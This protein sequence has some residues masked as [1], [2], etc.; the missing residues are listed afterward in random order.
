MLTSIIS[1]NLRVSSLLKV[2][3]NTGTVRDLTSTTLNGYFWEDSPKLWVKTFYLGLSTLI[4][5]VMFI[6]IS[7]MVMKKIEVALELPAVDG[8][9]F[10]YF[11]KE[12]RPS[13]FILIFDRKNC[14]GMGISIFS[15]K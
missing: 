2:K 9:S 14:D 1:A 7:K 4:S 15:Q 13:F 11:F 5:S 12:I 8:C 6:E 3:V 10:F